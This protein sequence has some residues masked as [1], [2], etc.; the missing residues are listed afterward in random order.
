MNM[1]LISIK[2]CDEVHAFPKTAVRGG[3][4]RVYPRPR[5]GHS[6]LLACVEVC[7]LVEWKDTSL[8]E[9]LLSM[10][11]TFCRA[12]IVAAYLRSLG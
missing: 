7:M 5:V 1:I 12:K 4:I 2:T 6:K 10:F 8:I 3:E 11:Q 9:Y